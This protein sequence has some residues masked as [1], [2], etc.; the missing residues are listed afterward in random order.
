MDRGVPPAGVRCD[1]YTPAYPLSYLLGKDMI[2][3]LRRE[4]RRSLGKAYSDKFFHDTFLYA[5]SIPMT[6]MRQ[7]FAYKVKELQ[8]LRRKGL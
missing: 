8:K 1:T 3:R 2:L 6:Y 7:I 5:G 4:V